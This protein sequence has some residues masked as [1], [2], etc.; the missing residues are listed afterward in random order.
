MLRLLAGIIANAIPSLIV[1]GIAFYLFVTYWQVLISLVVFILVVVILVYECT[2]TNITTTIKKYIKKLKIKNKKFDGN[3]WGSR[4]SGSNDTPSNS[5]TRD[6]VCWCCKRISPEHHY[7][8][9]NCGAPL[10]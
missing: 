5:K 4:S 9:M 1:F 3:A 8:C 10:P 7:K 2:T 6:K